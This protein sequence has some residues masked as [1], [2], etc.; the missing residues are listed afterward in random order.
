MRDGED[1]RQNL[2]TLSVVLTCTKWQKPDV[3]TE[4]EVVE[5]ALLSSECNSWAEPT[6]LCYTVGRSIA[7]SALARV[8]LPMSGYHNSFQPPVH[9]GGVLIRHSAEKVERIQDAQV[10]NFRHLKFS[11]LK[12]K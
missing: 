12:G 11:K 4:E 9:F 7:R 8:P 10:G 2:V 1:Q 3:L 6:R 5:T